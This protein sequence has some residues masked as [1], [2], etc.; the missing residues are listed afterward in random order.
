MTRKNR[1]SILGSKSHLARASLGRLCRPEGCSRKVRLV[2]ARPVEWEGI[3]YV[4]TN[5]IT[6]RFTHRRERLP[7]KGER[8]MNIDDIKEL[9]Q[10]LADTDIVEL[11]VEANGVK[12]KIKK[13]AAVAPVDAAAVISAAPVVRPAAAEA[14]SAPVPAAPAQA[15]ELPGHTTVSAPMVGTFYRA[16]SPDSAPYVNVGDSVEAGQPLCIIEAMKLMNE[17]ESEVRG[18]IVEI[19][20][21]NG[22]PVE[23]GQPL[24]VIST[25]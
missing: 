7:P 2:G 5:Q 6:I 12:V 23:Y 9:I 10:V 4:N 17:I 14:A 19:L 8:F 21:E 18:R 11:S 24:F 15:E 16:P 13:G 25:E 20:V 3:T 1:S 22:Q